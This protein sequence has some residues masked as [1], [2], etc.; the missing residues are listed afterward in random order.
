MTWLNYRGK[1]KRLM[2]LLLFVMLTR[3]LVDMVCRVI[4]LAMGVLLV[5][6]L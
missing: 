4:S 5:L 1:L 3:L 2:R 6:S